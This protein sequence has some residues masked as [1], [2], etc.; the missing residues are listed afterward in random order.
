MKFPV[1]TI[2]R[3]CHEANREYCKT[4]S[5]YSQS[6]WICSPKEQRESAIEGVNAMIENIE[7]TPEQCHEKWADFKIKHGW[8]YAPVKNQ[9]KKEHPNLVPYHKL[10]DREKMKDFL[11]RGIV[12]SFLEA[13]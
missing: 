10:T 11:F 12:K 6:M 1:E 3:V 9:A 2:A 7:L 4:L 8:K 13:V 5:D